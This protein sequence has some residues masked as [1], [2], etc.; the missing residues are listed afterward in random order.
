MLAYLPDADALRILDSMNSMEEFYTTWVQRE[1]LL[2]AIGTGCS[3][4]I[5][6][7]DAIT[8]DTYGVEKESFYLN[9]VEVRKGFLCYIATTAQVEIVQLDDRLISSYQT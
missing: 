9:K 6:P 8:T 1:A 3:Q 4:G 5:R 7:F 2:K